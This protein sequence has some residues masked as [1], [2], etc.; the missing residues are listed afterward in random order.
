[1]ISAA[2]TSYF[3][4]LLPALVITL[5]ASAILP[6]VN[7]NN[8]FVRTCAILLSLGLGW[9]YMTWRIFDTVPSANNPVDFIVGAIFTTVEAFTMLGATASQLFLTRTRNRTAEA[10]R[11][12]P[13]LLAHPTLPKVDVLICTYNENESISSARSSARLR[14]TIRTSEYGSATTGDGRGSMHFAK[15]TVSAI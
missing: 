11:N 7:R 13:K 8:A 12:V 3:D 2:G 4:A 6:W 10:D 1:M 5:L 14:S 9:R 15:S